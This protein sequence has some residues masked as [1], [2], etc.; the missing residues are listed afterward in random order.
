MVLLFLAL[1]V[2]AGAMTWALWPTATPAVQTARP[3]LPPRPTQ[4]LVDIPIEE[5][6]LPTPIPADA[7]LDADTGEPDAAVAKRP[8]K[9]RRRMP[10]GKID[11][12]RLQ[13][14]IRAKSGQVRGCYERRLKVN[15]LLQGTLVPQIRIHPNGSVMDVSFSQDTLHDREVR[16]CVTRTIRRWR[17]PQPEGGAVTVA[18]PYRFSPRHE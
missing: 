9:R 13:A 1:A 4:S 3:A 7:G 6:M 18:Y 15:S 16:S 17:F 12:R 2:G 14:F 8:N 11:R 5:P 10:E